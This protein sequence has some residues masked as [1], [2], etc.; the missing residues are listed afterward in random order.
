MS[1][2]GQG[3]AATN[4]CPVHDRHS[5]SLP[6]ALY[7]T[8]LGYGATSLCGTGLGYGAIRL[9]GT[10]LGYGASS[11]CGTDAGFGATSGLERRVLGRIRPSHPCYGP[12][13][14]AYAPDTIAPTH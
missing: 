1:G 4:P 10:G 7:G 11:L 8:V 14:S 9:C 2:T 3:Y 12:S 5:T 13:V 6:D